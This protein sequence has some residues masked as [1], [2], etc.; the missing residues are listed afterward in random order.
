MLIGSPSLLSFL[1]NLLIPV[2]EV[3]GTSPFLCLYSDEFKL[4]KR[5]KFFLLYLK[6]EI[7][8]SLHLEQT[9]NS[10][11]KSHVHSSSL[12]SCTMAVVNEALQ[13]GRNWFCKI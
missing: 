11:H 10:I 4:S 6:L 2:S 8:F 5:S 1:N 7:V 3:G 9:S 12:N 13:K